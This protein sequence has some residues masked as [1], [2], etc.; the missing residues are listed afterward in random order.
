MSDQTGQPDLEELY[1]AL[2]AADAS[3]DTE[4]ARR[5]SEYIQTLGSAGT[6]NTDKLKEMSGAPSW[7]PAS[8][9]AEGLSLGTYPAIRA[10]AGAPLVAQV[11]T[12]PSNTMDPGSPAKRRMAASPALVTA[13]QFQP[14]NLP[15]GMNRLFSTPADPGTEIPDSAQGFSAQN[16]TR[17]VALEKSR[18]QFNS[19]NP[20]TGRGLEFA[21]SLPGTI[22]AAALAP[23]IPG[24]TLLGKVGT[25]MMQGGLSG[26]ATHLMNRAAGNSL[27]GDVGTGMALG[28]AVPLVESG[29]KSLVTPKITEQVANIAQA[30]NQLGVPLRPGQLAQSKGW[31]KLDSLLASSG[32]EAQLSKFTRA[33]SNT[34]GEDTPTLTHEVFDRASTR[35]AQD[36]NDVAAKTK[37]VPDAPLIRGLNIIKSNS[38][39][40]Q[41]SER[42]PVVRMVD[43]IFDK[44]QSGQ[45]SG[46]DYQALTRRGTP[47]G[48]LQ[49]SP[50][51][52]VR[53]MGVQIRDALDSALERHAP[54]DQVAKL[55]EARSAWKNMMVI[56]PLSEK[57]PSG[58]I[59][60]KLLLNAVRKGYSD[61]G[62]SPPSPIQTLG[63]AGQFM[64]SATATGGATGHGKIPWWI[65]A[66]GIMGDAALYA[67]D[68]KAAAIAAGGAA[69]P[70]AAGKG[71]GSVM[72][73]DA[74]RSWALGAPSTGNAL[75]RLPFAV[76]GAVAASNQLTK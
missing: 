19:D 17:A 15:F 61:F 64:P 65:P 48:M 41:D 12:G 20:L 76:P 18:A 59:D 44:M 45:I 35:I 46:E 34:F 25:G 55:K 71:I 14:Q 50:N 54:A 74:Y 63:Q 57:A 43:D 70:W 28:G 52:N 22:G 67:H 39:G 31:Q 11:D 58:T 47:L 75:T 72:G 9:A 23:E 13:G 69:I 73:S 40:L 60:P 62:W 24:G 38:S 4:S 30:A 49:T 10:A 1:S 6:P 33:L 56:Q 5:L 7:G 16:A 68:P 27:T 2:R 3:G 53:Y 26:F 21:G 36:L 51:P 29:V 66:G 37:I 32:N 42:G 8:A